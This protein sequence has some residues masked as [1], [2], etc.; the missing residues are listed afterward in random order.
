MPSLV[1]F[2]DLIWISNSHCGGELISTEARCLGLVNWEIGEHNFSLDGFPLL[3]LP[4]FWWLL[5]RYTFYC[6]W[7]L[8]LISAPQSK[9]M[10]DVIFYCFIISPW[11][12]IC[13]AALIWVSRAAGHVLGTGI[14]GALDGSLRGGGST[15]RRRSDTR[16]EG[17]REAI[18]GHHP[19]AWIHL[20][21][22]ALK[23]H[24]FEGIDLH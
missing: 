6:L 12:I 4:P 2:V 23:Y 24:R 3:C 18:A 9:I 15:Q 1:A 8:L 5:P 22:S 13:G 19:S 14:T 11:R 7:W 10:N 17:C 21:G 16:R 20:P